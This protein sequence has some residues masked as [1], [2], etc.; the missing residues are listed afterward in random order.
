MSV[1]AP[2]TPKAARTVWRQPMDILA[3]PTPPAWI[4]WA[5]TRVPELLLDHANCEKKAASTALALMF[6]YPQHELLCHR[7]SRL[8]REELRHYEQVQKLMRGQGVAY[9][10][11]PAA[12]YANGLR[13]HIAREE[14]GKL[15]DTLIVGALIEAR[16]CER[17]EALV[18]HL[19]EELAEFYRGLAG[20]ERRHFIHYIELAESFADAPIGDR[21]SVFVQAEQALVQAPDNT[22]AFHSGPP[23][24]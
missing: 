15:V 13:E 17:F 5:V 18:P 12:R 21:I 16:S 6:R 8:A 9:A 19:P 10:F 22:F 3:C 4:E 20:S 1:H 7:M 14:P 2:S 23:A 24:A 11:V